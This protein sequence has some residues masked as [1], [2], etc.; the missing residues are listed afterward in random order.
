LT[1]YYYAEHYVNFNAL[2]ADLFKQYKIRIWM[3]AVNPASVVNPNGQTQIQPPS[4]HGPGAI[5]HTRT[6]NAPVSIGGFGN[7]AFRATEQHGK[8]WF[9]TD[10]RNHSANLNTGSGSGRGR[11]NMAQNINYDEGQ[12]AFSQQLPQYPVVQTQYQVPQFGHQHMAPPPMYN[13]FAY[14]NAT[15]SG[16]PMN[17]DGN[18]YGPPATYSTSP[19][20]NQAA[21]GPS[22]RGGYPTTTSTAATHAPVH[23]MASTAGPIHGSYVASRYGGTTYY[24]T[25]AAQNM[26]ATSGPTATSTYGITPTF[27]GQFT[28]GTGKHT[29]NGHT[30][31]SGAGVSGGYDPTYGMANLSF[32]N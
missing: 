25:A 22:Y 21:S 1:F 2:V 13:R 14:P 16:S 27:A 28:S 6:T 18:Y 5:L 17:Y 23:G 10:C 3:S 4:A 12:L 31:T 24:S 26:Y 20:F 7:N 15:A 29:G 30:V 19:A 8:C 32:G 11:R 9:N